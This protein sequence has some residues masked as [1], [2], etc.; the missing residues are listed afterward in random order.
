MKR[1]TGDHLI[2]MGFLIAAIG[3]SAYCLAQDKPKDSAEK[4]VAA[5][6][7]QIQVDEVVQLKLENAELSIQNKTNEIQLLQAQA[8]KLIDDWMKAK[9]LKSEEWQFSRGQDGKLS[10]VKS[11]AAAEK[12]SK[13]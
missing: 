7:Q 6:P 5:A 1:R 12:Q 8:K 10:V 2:G 9:G 3:L 4:P 13:P 11:Q